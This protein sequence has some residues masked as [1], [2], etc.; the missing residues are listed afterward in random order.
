MNHRALLVTGSMSHLE[1]TPEC[2]ALLAIRAEGFRTH[3]MAIVNH[4]ERAIAL[5]CTVQDERTGR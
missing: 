5:Y 2:A 1:D 4:A 3:N